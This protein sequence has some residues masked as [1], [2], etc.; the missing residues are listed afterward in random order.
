MGLTK[1]RGALTRGP[2]PPSS[3]FKMKEEFIVFLIFQW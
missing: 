3:G 2:Q 1:G